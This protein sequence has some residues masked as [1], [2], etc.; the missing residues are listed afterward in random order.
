VAAK[1]V[2]TLE[3][4]FAAVEAAP[5]PTPDDV[6][7]AADGTRLDNPEKVLAWVNEVNAGRAAAQ[8]RGA[9]IV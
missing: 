2:R 1:V 5:P 7:I 4:V 8:A 9:E 6:C 3:E